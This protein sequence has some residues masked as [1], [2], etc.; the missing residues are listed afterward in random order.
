MTPR[1]CGIPPPVMRGIFFT[2]QETNIRIPHINRKGEYT[3]T[4]PMGIKEIV[5]KIK[6]KL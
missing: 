5:T 1:V 4:T 6:E 3:N 2:I